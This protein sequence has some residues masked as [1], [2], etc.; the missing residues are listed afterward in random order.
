[1]EIKKNVNYRDEFVIGEKWQVFEGD[2]NVSSMS[3][4]TKD[5]RYMGNYIKTGLIGGIGTPVEHRRR[6]YVRKMFDEIMRE[7]PERGWAVSM[8]HPFSFPYYRKFGYER[9]SDHL[10]LEFPMQ[11]LDFVPRCSDFVPV[12]TGKQQLDCCRIYEKFA[13]DKNIM[14]RR[15]SADAF[16]IDPGSGKKYYLYYDNGE[17]IA[18]VQTQVENNY[19]IN[20]MVSVNLNVYEFGFVSVKGLFA[21]LGFLRMYEGQLESVK[22]HNAAMAPQLEMNLRYYNHTKYT[23]YPDIAARVTDFALMMQGRRWPDDSGCF[24]IRCV[25]P[26][27]PSLDGVWQV[28]YSGGKCETRKLDGG[29]EAD[30]TLPVTGLTQLLYGYYEFTPENIVYLP[31]AE[32]NNPKSDLFRVFHKM[33]NGLFEHF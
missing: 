7:I 17:P 23:V 28:E 12:N 20:R 16:P 8:L 25:D 11:A 4:N 14:F 21:M 27:L 19:S 6:S 1:M 22:I 13:E 9:I 18:F 33:E 31:G 3:V 24:T 30:L 10:V 29:K 32:L 5:S 15:V 2:E 26:Q